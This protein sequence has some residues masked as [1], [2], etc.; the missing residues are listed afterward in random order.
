MP[1]SESASGSLTGD[2]LLL[3]DQDLIFDDGAGTERPV[4]DSSGGARAV[5]LEGPW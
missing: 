1:V 4:D 2:A 5:A 3:I